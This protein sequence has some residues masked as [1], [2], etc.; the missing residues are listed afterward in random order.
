MTQTLQPGCLGGVCT[1]CLLVWFGVFCLGLGWGFFPQIHMKRTF[2]RLWCFALCCLT[3]LYWNLLIKLSCVIA[4]VP[5]FS[6]VLHSCAGYHHLVSWLEQVGKGS[7]VLL[8]CKYWSLLWPWLNSVPTCVS[9]PALGFTQ[10]CF[11]VFSFR[12]LSGPICL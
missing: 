12:G 6:D 5:L 1:V 9:I 4:L 2:W 8:C 3:R 11:L 7:V 10:M